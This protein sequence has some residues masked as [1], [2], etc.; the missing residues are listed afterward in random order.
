[1]PVFIVA[2]DLNKPGQL[3]DKLADQ[4]KEFPHCHAQGSVWFIEARGPAPA[5]R[6][7]LRTHIDTNDKLFVDQISGAW[8]GSGMPVCGKWL[9]DRG[10]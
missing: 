2:Y 9:N 4:L 10:L 5:L 7:V 3:H 1:M 8:A 6:D